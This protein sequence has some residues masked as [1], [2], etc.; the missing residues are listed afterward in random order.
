MALPFLVLAWVPAL[1]ARLPRPG[2]W[3]ETLKQF[4]AFPLYLTCVWL[5]WLLGRQA[6]TDLLAAVLAGLVLLGLAIW[7]GRGRRAARATALLVAILAVGSPLLQQGD[8]GRERLSQPYSPQKLETLLAEGRGVFI[9]LTADWC[10]S[11]LANERVAL[12]S[13]RFAQVLEDR[14]I[15][16]LKGDWTHR[17]PDITALLNEHGR[18]GVP[19]YLYY[20]PGESDARILPQMLTPGIVQRALKDS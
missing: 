3:M 17:N 19:L 20:P 15:A 10:L 9:N 18:S 5:L 13:E 1:L 12:S 2:P 7:L 11:C 6:G 16:Y 4:L 8:A 14:N